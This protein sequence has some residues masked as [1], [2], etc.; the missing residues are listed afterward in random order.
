MVTHNE[1]EQELEL[2]KGEQKSVK[3]KSTIKEEQVKYI[4]KFITNCIF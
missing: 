2:G 1:I 4:I 3:E